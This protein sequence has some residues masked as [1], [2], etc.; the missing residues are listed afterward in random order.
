VRAPAALALVALLGA[1]GCARMS[2]RDEAAADFDK[3]TS[4]DAARVREDKARTGLASLESAVADYVKAEQAVPAKLEQLVPKYIAEIPSLD[5]PECGDESNAVR[6][7]PADVLRDGVVDGGRLRGAGG[8]GYV[9]DDAR[10]VV[11]VDCR[12]NAPSG[13]PWYRLRGAY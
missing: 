5:V 9:H 4:A 10:V 7:Y 3:A 1:G 2:G 11:F 13:Q 8:W 6:G 12:K